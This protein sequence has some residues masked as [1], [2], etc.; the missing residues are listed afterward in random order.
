MPCLC[1]DPIIKRDGGNFRP[2][3]RPLLGA[4]M[5]ALGPADIN[6]LF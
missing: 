4:M 1:G 3:R 5:T 6:R 2:K